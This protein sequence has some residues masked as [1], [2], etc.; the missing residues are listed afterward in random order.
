MLEWN[1]I[2]WCLDPLFSVQG[3]L[4]KFLRAMAMTRVQSGS[5]IEG[6]EES[7]KH[8]VLVGE[9]TEKVGLMDEMVGI[10]KNGVGVKPTTWLSF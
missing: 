4:R 9:I 7:T 8:L 2:E 6:L 1:I 3:G 10:V 5:M